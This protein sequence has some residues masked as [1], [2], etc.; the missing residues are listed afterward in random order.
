[1]WA[2]AQIGELEQLPA[3]SPTDA[4][5]IYSELVEVI[6]EFFAFEFNVPVHSMT[7][8]EFLAQAANS[9]RLAEAPRQRLASLISNAD[10]MKFARLTVDE[11]RLLQAC[12][13]AK[14]FVH[15]CAQ[16]RAAME[17]EAG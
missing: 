10:E 2:L 6:R 15:E 7:T 3:E 11:Q 8:G 1:V 4:E 5:A 13:D 17:S 16:H 9:V 14:S 12:Q